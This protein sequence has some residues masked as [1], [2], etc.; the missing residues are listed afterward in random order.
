MHAHWGVREGEA[1]CLQLEL[2]RELCWHHAGLHGAARGLLRLARRPP[3]RGRAVL[4]VG[5]EVV[6]QQA[7]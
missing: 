3:A 6:E 2:H 7:A 1:C 5:S 4:G